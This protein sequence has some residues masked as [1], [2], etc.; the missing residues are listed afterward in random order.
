VP[1]LLVVTEPFVPLARYESERRGL[2]DTRM[3]VI[4][5]P[6]GGI[7]AEEVLRRAAAVRDDVLALVARAERNR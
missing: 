3:V 5:H 2:P 6:L 7:A 4:E 1:A